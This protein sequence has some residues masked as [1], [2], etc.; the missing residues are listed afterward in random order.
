MFS[1]PP[2]DSAFTRAYIPLLAPPFDDSDGLQ[3]NARFDSYS[4]LTRTRTPQVGLGLLFSD[5]DFLP[6]LDGP[7][8]PPIDPLLDSPQLTATN[9]SPGEPFR[10]DRLS[11]PENSSCAAD[12]AGAA[13]GAV[14]GASSSAFSIRDWI[15]QPSS[16][17]VSS[18]ELSRSPIPSPHPCHVGPS[19]KTSCELWIYTVM[20]T[21]SAQP[22]HFLE[23]PPV[24]ILLRL[25]FRWDDRH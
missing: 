9:D 21:C 16:S 3:S 18:D 13:A 7:M 11:V 6:H 8:S 5:S 23:C 4:N 1:T 15:I 19:P 20:L 12:E 25:R 22:L 14:L 10:F 24:S 2:G 17:P